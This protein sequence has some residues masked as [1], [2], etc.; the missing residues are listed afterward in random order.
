MVNVTDKA[1]ETSLYPLNVAI[2]HVLKLSRTETAA[3]THLP[4]GVTGYVHHFPRLVQAL[5]GESLN[6]DA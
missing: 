5:V 6:A 4:H 2:M 3:I 1:T